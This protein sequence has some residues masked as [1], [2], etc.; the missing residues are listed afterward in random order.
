MKVRF[1]D[2]NAQYQALKQEINHAVLSVL[3]SGQ[4]ILGPEVSS[5]EKVFADYAGSSYAVGVASG[6]DALELSLSA[7]DIKGGDEVITTPFTYVATTEAI[8]HAGAKIVFSEIE[9]DT[10]NLDP[11]K[12]E[13]KITSKTKAILPVHL[14]GQS[15][16]M[17]AL[18]K[19]AKKYNLKIIEDAAQAV[20]ASWDAYSIGH[21]SSLAC[22][23]FYPTKNLGA[24]GDAGIIT[25]N[26]KNLYEKILK[27]RYHGRSPTKNYE[28]IMRGRNSRLDSLQAAILQVKLKYL[29]QWNKSRREKAKKYDKLLKDLSYVKTP[30][31]DRETYHVYHAYSMRAE[32]RDQLKEFLENKNI[33]T[34]IYYPLPLHLQPLYQNLG[35]E[36]GDF[37][38]SEKVSQEVLALPM[39]PELEDEH[40][41]YVSSTIKAFYKSA[42]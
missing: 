15:C 2:I 9:E 13:D 5:F 12:M 20:G 37:P 19:I 6:T 10:Y 7:L 34:A 18:S 35:Y 40:I 24:C 27:L 32:K 33:D 25:T 29:T 31:V 42:G 3:E 23:S 28:Y 17:T 41:E 4:F 39:Y 22:Y 26:D 16:N 38:I 11:K 8:H 36:K 14:F 1:L 21:F 30:Y